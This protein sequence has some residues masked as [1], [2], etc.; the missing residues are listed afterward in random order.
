MKAN[1]LADAEEKSRPG[2]NPRASPEKRILQRTDEL[3]AHFPPW[4]R[5]GVVL[6]YGR[7]WRTHILE[8]Q[9][10]RAPKTA[11]A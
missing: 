3:A 10:C 1:L 5:L 4:W 7:L 11:P 9:F 2:P 8:T 6:R